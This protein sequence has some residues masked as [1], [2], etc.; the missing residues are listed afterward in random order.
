MEVII[1]TYENAQAQFANIVST[2]AALLITWAIIQ[3]SRVGWKAAKGMLEER[4][5]SKQT[6]KTRKKKE[7][8]VISDGA[9]ILLKELKQQGLLNDAGEQ[10]W[11]KKFKSIGLD[12][13]EEPNLLGKA[14]HFPVTQS[15]R[16]LKA[17]LSHR[18]S[19]KP[20][21]EAKTVV[22]QD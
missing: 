21:K 13:P 9:L 20:K 3:W 10:S 12:V 5:V 1:G 6:M 17:Y 14:L 8:Q 19:R 7:A 16:D 11:Q 2:V 18:L 22:F 15:M 4:R